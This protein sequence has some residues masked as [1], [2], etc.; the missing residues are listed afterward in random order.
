ML[1]DFEK[2]FYSV[3]WK[4]MYKTLRFFNFCA[5]VLQWV[6]VLYDKAK[7]CI[8]QKGIFSYFFLI[9]EGCPH[10]DP[11]SSY[12][13]S[14]CVESMGLI[15][16]QNKNIKVIGIEKECVTLLQYVDDTVLF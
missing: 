1:I 3:S 10:G 6:S 2:A 12:L 9:G 7:L 11:V 16:R 14:L 13:F 5:D 8:L 15:I 4:L